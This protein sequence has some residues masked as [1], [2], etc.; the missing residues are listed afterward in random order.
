[1]THIAPSKTR[2]AVLGDYLVAASRSIVID[3]T[4][5]SVTPSK[6]A[7]NRLD[8]LLVVSDVLHADTFHRPNDGAQGAIS[9]HLKPYIE[10]LV[11]LAALYA[12]GK[13]SPCEKKLKAI[14]NFWATTQCVSRNDINAIRDRAIEGLVVARGGI[15]VRKRTYALPEWFGD[16]GVPWHE[17]PASYMLEP[18]IKYPDRPIDTF[19]INVTRLEQRQPS[20]RVRKLLEHYFE[21]I[22]LKYVPTGDNPTGE[23]KKYKLWLDPMGQLVKQN[24]ETGETRTVSNG[25]GWSKRFCHDM[26]ENGVPKTVTARRK[27]HKRTL[28]LI[29]K[30]QKEVEDRSLARQYSSSPP[31]RRYSSSRERSRSSSLGRYSRSRSRS[32]DSDRGDSYDGPR[33]SSR[34]KNGRRS[35]FDREWESS[36]GRPPSEPCN[37]GPD[38]SQQQ[39]Y[40]IQGN[41]NYVPLP[42]SNYNQMPIAT[43]TP[44]PPFMP[45]Q[46]LE[47]PM[48]GFP[49]PL[50][51]SQ[52]NPGQIHPP[53]PPPPPPQTFN[54]SFPGA[55]PNNP[56]FQNNTYNFGNVNPV[57]NN[58]PGS[59]YRGPPQQSPGV[60]REGLNGGFQGRGGPQGG[61]QGNQQGRG[62]RWN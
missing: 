43:S 10:D 25:Y 57:Y 46:F 41:N 6:A 30:N 7:R 35:R 4:G 11:E 8:I 13:D 24:K 54:G 32:R 2:V 34:D 20:N 45:G 9:H 44:P 48:Q 33:P 14:V 26:L 50:L 51:P 47:Y 37:R 15:P 12:T 56:S 19:A 21:D 23:T 5:K 53:P 27:K 31:R 28:K 39:R 52:V 60:Y 59:G 18:M 22:D 62:G 16:R 3:P 29:E 17:L 55:P 1:L 42:P 61:Y 49:P 36:R 40:H 58:F 38:Q